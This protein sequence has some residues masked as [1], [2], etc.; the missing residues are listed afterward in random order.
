MD[1]PSSKKRSSVLWS[2]ALS[3]IINSMAICG[4]PVRPSM[5]FEKSRSTAHRD[6]HAIPDLPL[7]G[8]FFVSQF[9]DWL[10]NVGPKR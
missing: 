6:L 8:Q 2:G 10:H 9:V 3:C 1:H 4:T 7:D 5:R